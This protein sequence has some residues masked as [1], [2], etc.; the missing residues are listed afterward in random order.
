MNVEN[1][2]L[3]YLPHR[4]INLSFGKIYCFENMIVSEFHEGSFID[5]NSLSE[6][7]SE[8]KGYYSADQ[9]VVYISNRI[10]S[11]SVDPVGWFKIGKGYSGLKG[12]AIINYNQLNKKVFK[13]ERMFSKKP[14]MSFSSLYEAVNWAYEITHV[15]SNKAG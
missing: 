6:F 2:D 4:L 11:Y 7:I 12:I 3:I 9:K 14:M 5:Y 13:V 1:S 8:V 15:K 10:N